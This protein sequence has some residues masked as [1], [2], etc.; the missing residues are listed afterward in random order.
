[1]APFWNVILL[2]T[3]NTIIKQSMEKIL[4]SSSTS[5]STSKEFSPQFVRDG[6]I[7]LDKK[8]F[9][10]VIPAF[11]AER[12]IGSTILQTRQNVSKVIV[13]DDG[14]TDRTADIARSAGAE[15]IRLDHSTGRAYALLLGLRRAREQRCSVAVC[16]DAN[17]QYDSREIGRVTGKIVSG[18]ADLV[19]GS[20]YL[21][22]ESPLL[23]YEKYDKMM[24]ESGTVVTDSTSLFRAFSKRGLDYLD[25]QSDGFHLDRDLISHFDQQDLK[26]FEVPVSFSKQPVK[27][28]EWGF[29]IKVLAGM[30]AFNEEKFIAKTIIGA[31][32]F[33]DEVVVVDD[34]STDATRAIAQNLGAIVVQHPKNCGYGAAIRSIFETARRLHVDALVIIDSDGQHDPMDIETLVERLERGDIDVVIGSRFVNGKKQKIPLYRIFGMKVLD[35]FTQMAGVQG[36]LD[37]QSGFRAY[38]RKAIQSI[39]IS[40][41][42]MSAGSEILIQIAEQKLKVAEIPIEVRYDIEETSSQNPLQHGMSVIYSIIGLISYRRP[43]TA[44]GIPGLTLVLLGM[45]FG[46]RAFAEYYITSKFSFAMSISSAIFLSLGLLLISIGLI[47]NYVVALI[48]ELKEQK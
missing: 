21:E 43:L 4:T 19:I 39:R 42:G 30:P 1:M 33:V 5:K 28:I 14:S 6:D 46:F 47:L 12:V 11:D 38:G 48:K 2:I 40:G 29:S 3:L 45:I 25:F 13:V 24:L 35:R 15:V 41:T 17:G 16:I 44:F 22:R 10:A 34:G 32:K 31:Q 26:I 7:D 8:G 18:E 27:H 23:S 9:I 36:N 20:R 37:S